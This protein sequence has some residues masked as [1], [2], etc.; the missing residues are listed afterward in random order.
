MAVKAKSR[1]PRGENAPILATVPA[2]VTPIDRIVIDIRKFIAGAI[3]FNTKA[4]EK[5]GM[6]LTDMQMMLFRQRLRDHR[7]P[8]FTQAR[9]CEREVALL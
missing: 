6:S 7:P 3:F 9:V 2:P 4:A 5:I 1:S 8:A